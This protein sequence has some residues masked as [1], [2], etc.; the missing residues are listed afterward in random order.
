MCEP[1]RAKNKVG[2]PQYMVPGVLQ[3]AYNAGVGLKKI[4]EFVNKK[5]QSPLS[6][7][8]G[9]LLPGLRPRG[10][11]ECIGGGRIR[12]SKIVQGLGERT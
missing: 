8:I 11:S 5:R 6:A 7:E 12:M 2:V 9:D 3:F 1:E 4:G 10:V